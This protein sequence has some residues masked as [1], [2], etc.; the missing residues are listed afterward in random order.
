MYAD[1]PSIKEAT[2]SIDVRHSWQLPIDLCS[3][4]HYLMTQNHAATDDILSF[5]LYLY[6]ICFIGL[7][8][9]RRQC[10]SPK[11]MSTL[12]GWFFIPQNS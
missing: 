6:I 8:C 11:N 4:L 9:N 3:F 1:I 12:V 10:K 5:F 7:L 2:R